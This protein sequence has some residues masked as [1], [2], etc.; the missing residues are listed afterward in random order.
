MHTDGDIAMVEPE[1]R[2]HGFLRPGSAST[3]T[4]CTRSWPRWPSRLG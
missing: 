2:E 1:L 3:W 4:R